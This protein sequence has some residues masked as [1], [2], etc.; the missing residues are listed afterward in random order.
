MNRFE[1]E[2]HGEIASR[3]EPIAAVCLWEVDNESARQL[4]INLTSES[5]EFHPAR[6]SMWTIREVDFK[7]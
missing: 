4:A 5:M 2:L 1:I 7:Q 6:A 3:S